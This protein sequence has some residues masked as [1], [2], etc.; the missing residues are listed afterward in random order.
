MIDKRFEKQLA[1]FDEEEYRQ[2]EYLK[3]LFTFLDDVTP[4]SDWDED[5]VSA[6]KRGGN[7][8]YALLESSKMTSNQ[9]HNQAVRERCLRHDSVERDF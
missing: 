8:R 7:K 4:D 3:D 2:L 1:D 5:E 9:L 6:K